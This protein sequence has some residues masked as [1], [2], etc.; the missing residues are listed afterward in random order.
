[1]T[2]I[3]PSYMVLAPPP[4]FLPAD[5]ITVVVVATFALVSLASLLSVA[6]FHLKSCVTG[7]SVLLRRRFLSLWPVRAGL[8]ASGLLL[9]LSHLLR[10][11]LRR[12]FLCKLHVVAAQGLFQPAFFVALL[13]LLNASLHKPGALRAA[14]SLV[15]SACLPLLAAHALLAFSPAHVLAWVEAQLRLPQGLFEYH[16]GPAGRCSYPLFDTL[17]VGGFG[18]GYAVVF[19]SACWRAAELA[20][21]RSLRL[22]V[23]RLGCAVAYGLPVQA[24]C[25]V[26]T[27]FWRPGE[28]QFQVV[29]TAAM[30]AVLAC[31]AVGE[32]TLVIRPIVDALE[33]GG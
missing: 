10:L 3:I 31:A 23:W 2:V 29:S 18:V 24:L 11:P 32:F 33:V 8:A 5:L 7:H 28:W 15:A 20:I 19:V 1:M 6:R 26:M 12:P 4:D 9:S 27:L 25:L 13:Y 16:S 14:L 30:V 22:R 21:N 17:L